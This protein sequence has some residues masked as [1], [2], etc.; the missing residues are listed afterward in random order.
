MHRYAIEQSRFEDLPDKIIVREIGYMDSYKNESKP[1]V[2]YVYVPEK[3]TCRNATPNDGF[4]CS[5][6]G[7][8]V[9]THNDYGG[10]NTIDHLNFCPSCGAKILDVE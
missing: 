10:Y 5:N 1:I 8:V 4:T 6:C 3:Q 2:D 7:E 9:E